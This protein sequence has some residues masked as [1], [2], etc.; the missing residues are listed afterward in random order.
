MLRFLVFLCCASVACAT[1]ARADLDRAHPPAPGPAPAASFPDYREITLPNGLKVFVIENHRQPTVTFRL[2]VRAGAVCD[3][4]KPG[5]AE[6][7]AELLNK[8]TARRDANAFAQAADTLGAVIEAGAG[9]D[10]A[11]VY[12]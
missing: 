2:L 9:E 1:A 12:A 11:F 8:G 5:T 3:G 4:P 7:A 10:A 6:I